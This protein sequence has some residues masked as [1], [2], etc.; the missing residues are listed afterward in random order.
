MRGR[1]LLP[2]A[3]ATELFDAYVFLR[4]V[5]H[6]LQYRDDAQTQRPAARRCRSRGAGRGDGVLRCRRVRSALDRHRNDVDRHFDALFFR[7]RRRRRA[8]SARCRLDRAGDPKTPIWPRWPPPGTTIHDALIVELA[9]VRQ[10]PRYLQLPTASRSRFDALVPQLLRAAAATSEPQRCSSVCLRCWRRSAG[11]ALIW[12]LLVEHP[13]VLPRI[14]QLM[15]ASAWAADYLMRHPMLLDELLDS[16]A[17]LDRARLECMA[18]ASSLHSL[19]RTRMM[20]NGRWMPCGISSRRRRFVCL[21]RTWRDSVGR[22]ARRPSVGA[23]RHRAR[24][25]ARP[26]LD[27]MQGADAAPPRFAIIGYGKL[28]GKELGYASDLD[29]VFLY[30]DPAEAAPQAYARLAQRL[31]DLAHQHDRGRDVCT[32]PT[33]GFVPTARAACWCRVS[34]RFATISAN[35][36]DLGAPGADARALRRRRRA[37][38]ARHSSRARRGPASAAR[39]RRACR[40]HRRNAQAECRRRIRIEARCSTSSTIRAAWSTSNSPC[41]SWSLRTATRMRS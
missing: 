21:R 13:P 20:P 2:A 39:S 8:R 30:D 17:L 35:S 4:M 25:C 38:S 19:P 5:E 37:R 32:T 1:G 40:R 41:S 29:L 18:Q 31:N 26:L 27:P 7:R 6:R 14:A 15:G 16:R 3:A 10:S 11:A 12:R 23:R 28:G 34:S 24:R 22:A 33:C 9:R 36:V